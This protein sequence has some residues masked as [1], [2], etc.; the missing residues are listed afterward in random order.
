MRSKDDFTFKINRNR[1]LRA[2]FCFFE[3]KKKKPAWWKTT[4][5]LMSSSTTTT[6]SYFAKINS[7]DPFLRILCQSDLF[8]KTQFLLW[9]DASQPNSSISLLHKEIS[10]NSVTEPSTTQAERLMVIT[11]SW[12]RVSLVRRFG[13]WD[14]STL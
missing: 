8:K 12:W 13:H 14:R 11:L 6:W 1:L 2:R 7:S 10:S 3:R 5:P 4:S 9:K